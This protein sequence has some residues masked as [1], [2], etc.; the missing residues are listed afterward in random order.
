MLLS[1][2]SVIEKDEDRDFIMSL[3]NKYNRLVYKKIKDK[4]ETDDVVE[5]L[6]NDTF[7]KLIE[8]I[9]ILKALGERE[10]LFYI[11]QTSNHVAV[12]YIKKC[13][14]QRK[15]V[16]YGHQGD[17]YDEIADVGEEPFTYYERIEDL[18]KAILQLSERDANL[19]IDK[20]Y[21][22]MTD[23]EIATEVGIHENSVRQYLTRARRRTRALLEGMEKDEIE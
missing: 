19:L 17:I 11:V 1:V 18:A 21:L 12:D 4:I 7:I 22:N 20:Y 14:V 9:V 16:Y 5:D 6:A 13:Q 2:I 15:H 23:K 8:K 10:L 3:Y